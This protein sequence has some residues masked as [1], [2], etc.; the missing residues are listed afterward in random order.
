M[1]SGTTSSGL[2][3]ARPFRGFVIY[4]L[5]PDIHT[6]F[7]ETPLELVLFPEKVRAEGLAHSMHTYANN[8]PPACTFY[9]TMCKQQTPAMRDGRK[10]CR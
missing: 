5:P 8:R 9:A 2:R 1:Y 7:V 4:A 10:A 3:W 6:D